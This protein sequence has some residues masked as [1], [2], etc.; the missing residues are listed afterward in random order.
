MS[1]SPNFTNNEKGHDQYFYIEVE[2][3]T[4]MVTAPVLSGV[5]RQFDKKS[6]KTAQQKCVDH[7]V[8]L[9]PSKTKIGVSSPRPVQKAEGAEC[10]YL[11]IGLQLPA[12]E[13][14]H[15]DWI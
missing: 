2:A 5:L 9:V 15:F 14:A 11:A 6:Q 1:L 13:L 10:S 4:L 7:M 8:P 12:Q 3:V